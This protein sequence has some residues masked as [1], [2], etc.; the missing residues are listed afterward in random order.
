MTA[1]SP[2][3]RQS[4]AAPAPAVPPRV[5]SHD[6]RRTW[7][8]IAEDIRAIA[9][10]CAADPNHP[11]TECWPPVAEIAGHLDSN[12]D[13]VR[14]ALRHLEAQGWMGKA[15]VPHP[16]RGRVDRWMP[17][18]RRPAFPEA[19]TSADVAAEVVRKC[20]AGD[21]DVVPS[22]LEGARHFGVSRHVM[23][24]V[25]KHLEAQGLVVKV[26]VN[27]TP[28]W[29]VVPPHLRRQLD[30]RSTV[31][32]TRWVADAIAGRI[33][34]GEFRYR[35]PDGSVHEPPFPSF[36][37]LLEQY[38]VSTTTVYRVRDELCALGLIAP[39]P[40][41]NGP[42]RLGDRVPIVD[43]HEHPRTPASTPRRAG[44][45]RRR[46]AEVADDIVSRI[47]E[48]ALVA[49]QS[50]GLAE[51]MARYK[52][53]HRTARLAFNQ[54]HRGGWITFHFNT[55]GRHARVADPLPTHVGATQGDQPVT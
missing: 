24:D 27:G 34:A 15:R 11:W 22:L 29:R 36:R 44:G 33:A 8:V 43:R 42:Y 1:P 35:L 49:A 41:P 32:P 54:A 37:R 7:H 48:G 18:V 21:W 28:R 4:P 45:G 50:V 53:S 10:L 39:G 46:A 20:L 40:R 9:E 52:I 19:P 25:T 12:K 47:R 14:R 5:S 26:W 31:S 38:G 23:V 2:S 3:A 17:Q 13:T 51:T 30:A 55:H 16:T 6:S